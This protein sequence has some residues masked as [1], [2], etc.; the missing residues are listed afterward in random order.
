MM[1]TAGPEQLWRS[2]DR[3]RTWNAVTED[4][5]I[6]S[7]PFYFTDLRVGASANG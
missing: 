7:H 1:G 6:N 4:G 5:S 3:G 2:D